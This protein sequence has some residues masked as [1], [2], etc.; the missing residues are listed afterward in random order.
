MDLRDATEI[1]VSLEGN[2]LK[3]PHT[4]N[5]WVKV[6][7]YYVSGLAFSVSVICE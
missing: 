6:R 5:K 1:L 7:K 3:T 2:E 4:L